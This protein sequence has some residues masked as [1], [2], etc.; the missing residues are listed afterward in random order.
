[1]DIPEVPESRLEEMEARFEQIERELSDP[2]LASRPDDLQRL[3]REHAELREVVD[4][5]RDYRRARDDLREA[6]S[7]LGGASED[8]KTYLQQ[9]IDTQERAVE[10]LAAQIVDDLTPKDP[11]D[12]RDVI[13]EIR[14]GAGGE[15]AALFA[16]ELF[17]MY[18]RFAENHRWKLEV[19]E[20]NETG[21]GGVKEVI[22]SVKGKDAYSKLKFEAGVHRVQRVPVT[23]SSGRI[24]TSAAAVLVLPEAEEVDVEIDPKDL[25]I[26]V[27]R[28]SGPGGQS[29][30]T[31][32][33]AVR[34]THLPTGEVVSCQDEKSQLQ[35][36]EKA[37]RI[38]RARLLQ[39]KR[40][41]HEQKMAA[42][43]KSQVRTAD[44][45]EKVRTYNYPQNRVTD[46]R[47]KYTVNRLPEFLE[48][49]IDEMIDVL[50][51]REREE[52]LVGEPI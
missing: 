41:E 21:Q 12:E 46:H 10:A 23:E 22:F 28:S 3:G 6:R 47:V 30:N 14:A 31:T 17:R 4:T 50:Q 13:V 45:S 52:R 33:S 49:D 11:L 43:R 29:V 35:N 25:R 36:R 2:E 38:L 18:S 15:E 20:L 19:L 7:M 37:M 39:L 26:D 42:E 8:E 48:G 24:H 5:W 40:E 9:E 44:R 32:D 34:I 1:M 27:Y 16:A 51:A